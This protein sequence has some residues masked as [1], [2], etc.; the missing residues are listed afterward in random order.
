M[1]MKYIP[2]NHKAILISPVVKHWK[3]V[4]QFLQSIVSIVS[5]MPLRRYRWSYFPLIRIKIIMMI[6][7]YVY[8]YIMYDIH[9]STHPSSDFRVRSSMA[10]PHH[11]QTFSY[12]WSNCSFTARVRRDRK[13]SIPPILIIM[14]I[15]YI[16]MI[17]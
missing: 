2:T 6:Y 5:S 16:G 4:E 10:F 7:I 8:I 12:L 1:D 11:F 17:S 9:H 13:K 15:L 14:S 3:A